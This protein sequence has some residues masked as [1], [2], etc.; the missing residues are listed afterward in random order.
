ME[1]ANDINVDGYHAYVARMHS[2]RNA[3]RNHGFQVSS[4]DFRGNM[5]VKDKKKFK[6]RI[7]ISCWPSHANAIHSRCGLLSIYKYMPAFLQVKHTNC[8]HINMYKALTPFSAAAMCQGRI[9]VSL[10]TMPR[11]RASVPRPR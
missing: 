6:I 8:H 4:D 9:S 2:I 10:S 3:M 7:M 5:A 11:A 1:K